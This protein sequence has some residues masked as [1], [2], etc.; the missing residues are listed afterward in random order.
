MRSGFQKTGT[1]PFL[2]LII[3]SLLSLVPTLAKEWDFYSVHLAYLGLPRY[4]GRY[5]SSR[6]KNASIDTR[7][8][9]PVT[10]N[11]CKSWLFGD[12]YSTCGDASHRPYHSVPN[13]PP[14]S[15]FEA[16]AELSDDT[17]TYSVAKGPSSITRGVS[18]FR[19]FVI[20]RWDDQLMTE[21]ISP[22]HGSIDEIST[23]P[24]PTSVD[25]LATSASSSDQ[26]NQLEEETGLDGTSS[27]E[28]LTE[29]S[30]LFRWPMLIHETWQQVCHAGGYYLENLTTRPSTYHRAPSPGSAAPAMTGEQAHSAPLLP[31]EQTDTATNKPLLNNSSLAQSDYALGSGDTKDSEETPETPNSPAAIAG[32]SKYTGFRRDSDYMRGSSMAIVIAL[33]AGILWF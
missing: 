30:L 21:S 19:E 9:L 7:S 22:R 2:A 8:R 12:F 23:K 14:R 26:D 16:G 6:V 29:D 33:V 13:S 5:S 20:W 24:T 4:E 25:L 18:A 28:D 32:Q 10:D 27:T 1:V 31:E 15:S 3:F 11:N 17:V